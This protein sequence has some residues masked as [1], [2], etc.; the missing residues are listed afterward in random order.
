MKIRFVHICCILFILTQAVLTLFLTALFAL[1]AFVLAAELYD[2]NGE[3]D[4]QDPKADGD[5]Y[6]RGVYSAPCKI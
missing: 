3:E 5:P 4:R 1:F 6:C 2:G